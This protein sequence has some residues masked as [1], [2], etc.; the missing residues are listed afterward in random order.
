MITM[1]QCY[2]YR[3]A[4]DNTLQYRV[5]WTGG[6]SANAAPAGAHASNR[7]GIGMTRT[8]GGSASSTCDFQG[9]QYTC[10]G[11][12]KSNLA[13]NLTWPASGDYVLTVAPVDDKH[14]HKFDASRAKQVNIRVQQ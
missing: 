12:P 9:G 1:P 8:S 13:F 3:D 6:A 5:T 14:G 10:S 2:P 4:Q 11:A 7:V